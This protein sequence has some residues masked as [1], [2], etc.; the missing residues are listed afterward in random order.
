MTSSLVLDLL[1]WLRLLSRAVAVLVKAIGTVKTTAT[2]PGLMSPPVAVSDG[3]V[4]TATGRT[5]ALL[6]GGR[7][8]LGRGDVTPHLQ[9]AC[10]RA[11]AAAC[12]LSARST[13]MQTARSL[14]LSLVL[15]AALCALAAPARLPRQL[16]S[17]DDLQPLDV[18]TTDHTRLHYTFKGLL[19]RL[20]TIWLITLFFANIF[21]KVVYKLSRN[22]SQWPVLA[23][24][25]KVD[26]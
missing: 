20:W 6:A 2:R 4:K 14:A 1:S 23:P 16:P 5:H 25:G 10:A 3:T 24:A 19:H 9:L 22:R 12:R 15:L 18:R 11:A 17:D 7:T 26:S 13:A 8:A 21:V